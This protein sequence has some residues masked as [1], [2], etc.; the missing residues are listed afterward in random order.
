MEFAEYQNGALQTAGAD[1]FNSQIQRLVIATLGLTGEAGEVAD[2]VKK[3]A[4]H[5]HGIEQS[6]IMKELGDVL[7]YIAEVCSTLGIS[8]SAVAEMN[9]EKLQNRYPE[10]FSEV[11]SINR[12]E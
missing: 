3:R 12:N 4:A 11:R 2:M 7:W 9:L 1:R 6:E 10:G 8:M 5:G